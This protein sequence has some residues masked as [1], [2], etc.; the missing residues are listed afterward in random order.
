M[1]AG[2]LVAVFVL[3]AI[4]VVGVW[5]LGSRKHTSVEEP[6]LNLRQV[7]EICGS[8]LL[9]AWKLRNSTKYTNKQSTPQK[10]CPILGV[11]DD[12]K[13]RDSY[14]DKLITWKVAVIVVD[15]SVHQVLF[16]VWNFIELIIM[17]N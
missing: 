16:K 8:E 15:G 7:H 9:W 6:D 12:P 1:K 13:T 3:V 14:S 4:G 5:R 10:K 11:C 17:N 2:I